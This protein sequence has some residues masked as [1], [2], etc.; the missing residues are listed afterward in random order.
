MPR[1]GMAAC[2]CCLNIH[3]QIGVR[4]L[5]EINAS[6]AVSVEPQLRSPECRTAVFER[7]AVFTC[8]IEFYAPM[9]GTTFLVII[10]YSAAV[11]QRRLAHEEGH[12]VGGLRVLGV[13]GDL[14]PCGVRAH[15]SL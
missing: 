14:G 4:A 1:C 11:H 2:F 5:I 10:V 12:R 7:Q 8:G 13:V 9:S 15:E 3:G 6:D